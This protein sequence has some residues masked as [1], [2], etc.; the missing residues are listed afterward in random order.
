VSIRS[1][2]AAVSF[3]T[4]VPVAAPDG[5]AGDR[6]GRAYFPAVGAAVGALAAMVFFFVSAIATPLLAAPAA[7][8]VL[9]ALTGALHVDGLADSVDGLL[10]AR[11]REKRL[12]VMRDPHLGSYAVAAVV[13]VLVL[14]VAALA[15]M[16]P[17]RAVVALVVAGTLSRLA[18]LVLVAWL[19]YV[20]ADGLGTAATD[21]RHRGRDLVVGA[22]T[23]LVVCLLD[24]RRAAVAAAVCALIT[25]LV[26]NHARRRIGGATGDV[27]GATSELAQMATLL[28]FAVR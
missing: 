28:V 26:A 1:L 13:V 12:E 11:D 22:L 10:G 2:R 27:Y 20:R 24:W 7:V 25:L 15:A 16:S 9:V 19:P 18:S 8:A 23:A 3:L 6:L 5:S 21:A 17:A 14:Q 4:V